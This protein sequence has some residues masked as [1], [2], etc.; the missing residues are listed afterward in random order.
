MQALAG[1]AAAFGELSLFRDVYCDANEA[2][3]V[4][5]GVPDY[6]CARAKPEPA[7]VGVADAESPVD[8]LLG[9]VQER[10]CNFVDANYYFK[11]YYYIESFL[12]DCEHL[13]I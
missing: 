10:F 4:V 11:P 13:W 9:R 8:V 12:I 5:M 6:F 1:C 2:R 3:A 7:A